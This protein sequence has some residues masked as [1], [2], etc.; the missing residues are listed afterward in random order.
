MNMTMCGGSIHSFE[1]W[2]LEDGMHAHFPLQMLSSKRHGLMFIS[3][4]DRKMRLAGV[5]SFK[6]GFRWVCCNV[7][8]EKPSFT[9][10]LVARS[11]ADEV[12]REILSCY[13][14]VRKLGK[15][16]VYL[17]SSRIEPNHSNFLQAMELGRE[18]SLLLDCTSWTGVGPG[19]MDAVI[20]GALEAK[21]PVGG[22]KISKEAGEWTNSNI[23]PYLEDHFYHTCRFFSARKHGLVDAAVR[24]SLN[25]RTAFIALP[26][27]IGTLD[28]IFEILT[29]IQLQRIGSMYPVPFLLM[30]YGGF[31]S[32]LLDF[33]NT[34]KVWGTVGE[35][36][37]E[38]LWEVCN[39][40][41]EALQYLAEYYSIA[42]GNQSF[43]DRVRPPWSAENL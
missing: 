7:K 32:N 13:K 36:E 38:K 35:G 27:G 34:C 14:L 12:R 8:K 17:G 40:N 4:N 41:T 1:D 37:M 3:R 42:Q 16:V 11:S 43:R 31:Y 6:K 22:F 9:E 20:K 21:K 30:N 23:H 5:P 15:G 33:L 39:N 28:E 19:M 29:L 2:I 18:V 10:E 25:D 26:G 24:D